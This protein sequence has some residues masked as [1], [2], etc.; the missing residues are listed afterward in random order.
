MH[1]STLIHVRQERWYVARVFTLK[2]TSSIWIDSSF[3]GH[4]QYFSSILQGSSSKIVSW[5]TGQRSNKSFMLVRNITN[6][7]KK[8]TSI[9]LTSVKLLVDLWPLVQIY[10]VWR[11]TF[12]NWREILQ[13]SLGRVIYSFGRGLF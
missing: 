4:L 6:K 13:V 11:G 12:L 9:F 1:I 8:P 3:E 5:L 2:Q 7:H 10:K